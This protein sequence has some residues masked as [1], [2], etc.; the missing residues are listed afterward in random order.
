MAPLFWPEVSCQLLR[1]AKE[2][3]YKRRRRAKL[4]ALAGL[5]GDELRGGEPT[6]VNK[7]ALKA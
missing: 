1:G 3:Q 4:M 7:F 2:N 5:R 6:A